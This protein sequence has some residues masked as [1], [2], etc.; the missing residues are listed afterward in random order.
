M[1]S[2]KNFKS[3]SYNVRNTG[4]YLTEIHKKTNYNHYGPDPQLCKL[5]LLSLVANVTNY[6]SYVLSHCLY[7]CNDKEKNELS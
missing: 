7:D 2:Y 4:I 1:F 3:L 6:S 5:E